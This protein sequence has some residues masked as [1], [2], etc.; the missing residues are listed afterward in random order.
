MER[1]LAINF[2]YNAAIKF[3]EQKMKFS[4]KDFLSKCDQIHRK[5]RIWSHL[6]KKSLM[7]NFIFCAVVL[8]Q[9]FERVQNMLLRRK[10]ESATWYRSSFKLGNIIKSVS[11]MDRHLTGM[12][13]FLYKVSSYF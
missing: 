11:D 9:I 8:S 13:T 7:K 3:T 6:L 10:N 4:N 2:C 12:K 1:P 5:Q